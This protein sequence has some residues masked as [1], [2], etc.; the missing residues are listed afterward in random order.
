MV[1]TNSPVTRFRC[2]EVDTHVNGDYV[3]DTMVVTS[4]R[5][6]NGE[7]PTE[8][9]YIGASSIPLPNSVNGH[10]ATLGISVSLRHSLLHN[11]GCPGGYRA[12]GGDS[13]YVVGK[14]RVTGIS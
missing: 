2:A 4:V 5:W 10:A 9:A 3:L 13:T 11:G 7:L 14:E 8:D 1:V 6:R 12:Q